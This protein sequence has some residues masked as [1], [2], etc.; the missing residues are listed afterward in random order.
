MTNTLSLAIESST[1]DL[2]ISIYSTINSGF[3]HGVDVFDSSIES[4]WTSMTNLIYKS[5]V[6]MLGYGS[7][8]VNVFDSAVSSGFNAFVQKATY[9]TVVKASVETTAWSTI[10]YMPHLINEYIWTIP[11]GAYSIGNSLISLSAIVSHPFP[12]LCN[13]QDL[14]DGLGLAYWFTIDINNGNLFRL[15][16]H[17]FNPLIGSW[18]YAQYNANSPFASTASSGNVSPVV[19]ISAL[20]FLKCF[21]F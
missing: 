14:D 12:N 10:Y 1:V 5:S 3:N 20:C 4:A 21:L 16:Q 6:K 13:W 9:G 18:L 19:I 15:S 7:K 8:G 11:S 2:V 17:V